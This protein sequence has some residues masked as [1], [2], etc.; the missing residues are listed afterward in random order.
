MLA[1]LFSCVKINTTADA[2]I[3]TINFFFTSITLFA[4]VLTI[5]EDSYVIAGQII[6][7][8]CLSLTTFNTVTNLEGGQI[9]KGWAGSSAWLLRTLSRE[10]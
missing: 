10:A 7:A 5:L 9:L 1:E 8:F 2:V 3:Y 4:H 6:F